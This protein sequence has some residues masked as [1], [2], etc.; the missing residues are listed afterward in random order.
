MAP[1]MP[2]ARRSAG[3]STYLFIPKKHQGSFGYYGTGE[4][5]EPSSGKKEV[6]DDTGVGEDVGDV[7]FPD[8]STIGA[9]RLLMRDQWNTGLH[10][11]LQEEFEKSQ[12]TAFPDVRFHKSRLSDFWGGS[13]PVM[14]YLKKKG[15]TTLLFTGVDTDQYVLA[16]VQDACN[17][18]F[19]TILL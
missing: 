11:P 1:E 17:M 5:F 12:K 9:G 10:G 19:D 7:K 4:P 3:V 2:D 18:G 15:I 13:T 6:K 14:E 8:G 16:S